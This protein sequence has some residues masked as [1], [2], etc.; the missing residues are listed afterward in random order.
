MAK[1]RFFASGA[2]FGAWLREHHGTEAELL[3]GFWKIGSGRPS[4]TWPESVEQ[5]L[6]YGWIDGVRRSLGDDAYTIRFTPRRSG[7]IWSAKNLATM[8]RLLDAGRAAPAGRAVYEARDE[9][10]TN[11]YSFERA[12]IAFEPQQEKLFRRNR[13]GWAFFESQPPSYRKPAI[14]W[15]VSAKKPET[16]AKRLAQLIADSEAGMRIAQLRR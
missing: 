5:A 16:R 13:K 15:V 1:A 2:E 12:V 14:H 10:K 11:R 7:S 4:M 6:C 8:R 3:V 9:A